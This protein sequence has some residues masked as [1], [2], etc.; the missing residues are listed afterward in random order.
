MF[1]RRW[2]LAVSLAGTT[3]IIACAWFNRAWLFEALGLLHTANP[4]LLVLAFAVILGGYLITSHVLQLA[5]RSL[6]YSFG[7]LRLW[8][9]AL[10]AVLISQSVP[11]GAVGSY[12]FIVGAVNR[13]GVA[14]GHAALVATL[15]TLSYGA[16]MLLMFAFSLAYLT[17]HHLM[18]GWAS[19][20]A[21]AIGVTVLAGISVGLTRPAATLQ[22]WGL[23]LNGLAG[24]LL[25]RQFDPAWIARLVG[26]VVRGRALLA[27]QPWLVAVLVTI[28]LLALSAHSLALWLILAGLGVQ[29]SFWV[30]SAALGVALITSTFNVLPGGGGTVEAALVA[31]L[32]QL[33][34]GPAAVPATI[35]FR[36]F[37]FWLLLPLMGLLY[38]WLLNEAPLAARKPAVARL[39]QRVELPDL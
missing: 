32:S 3:I 31:V 17:A 37:N 16:A 30:V 36:L 15:E 6:G 7:P 12:A 24:L 5:L 14:P 18:T 8:A 20:L 25:R 4:L 39:N 23:K 9:T 38:H 19:Y 10:V 13:R 21:A 22:T 11:A 26:E 2:K 28:Q 1:N 33:G 34:A 29:V 27:A 35:I